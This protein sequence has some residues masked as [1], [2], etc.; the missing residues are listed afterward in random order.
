[1]KPGTEIEIGLSAKGL[2]NLPTTVSEDDFTFVVGDSRYICPSLFACF[3]SPRICDLQRND[4]TIREFHVETPDSNHCFESILKL[5]S[6]SKVRLRGNDA[7]VRMVSNEL[8]NRE[9][10]EAITANL[11]DDLSVENIFDRLRFEFG[12]GDDCEAEIEFCSSH[13]YEL[14][15]ADLRSLPFELFSSIISHKSIRLKD[16]DSFYSIIH[17]RVCTE[18]D[19]LGLFEYVRF[20]YLSSTSIEM[21]IELMN[22]SLEGMTMGLWGSLCRRLSFGHRDFR[23]DRFFGRFNYDVC[24]F[25]SSSPLDGI[26]SHLSR[27]YGG[28]VSDGEIISITAS[29]IGS[30]IDTPEVNPLG[31]LASVGHGEVFYTRNAANS[32]ICYDF[33]EMQISLTHYSIRTDCDYQCYHLRSWILEG[34]KNGLSWTELDRRENDT[35][36]DSP[37]VIG[38]FSIGEGNG[39]GFRMIRLQQTGRNS[40]DT[41]ELVVTAIEFFGDIK[42]LKQ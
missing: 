29:G 12:I 38:T 30:I 26:L 37:G 6:G 3:V 1:M 11:Q 21:F 34:S 9:L 8:G 4:P 27:K 25:V 36:L 7:F 33:K 19:F 15:A 13:L 42:R 18:S 31:N 40:R 28:H 14:E 24:P 10:Y 35:T 2:G 5:C 16:E 17:S 23:D 39:E 41:D 32:W 20:E 22:K